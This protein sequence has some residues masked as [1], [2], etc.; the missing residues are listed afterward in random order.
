[1][2]SEDIITAYKNIAVPSKQEQNLPGLDKDIEP[3]IE[4]TKQ[5]IWDD[6]GRPSLREY[7][8]SGK[9][10]GKTAIVTGADSGIGR[11]AVILFARE[12]ARGITIAH[13]PEEKEDAESAKIDL[14]KE[15]A[16]CLLVPCN[17]MEEADCKAVV[18]AHVRVFGTLNILVNN[19]SKQILTKNFEEIDLEKVK[20]TFNSN[21]LQMFAVTK[22]ALPH[23]KRGSSIINTTS[24]TAYKGSASL[25]DYS[26]T[27]GAI[28]TFT[29]SLAVQLAPKGIRVNAIAPGPVVTALQAASRDAEDMEG[30]GVGL[31]LHNRAA[32]PAELGPAYVFLAS[33]D[34]NAMTGAVLHINS[35][36]HIGGS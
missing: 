23:M 17:L 11:S 31:P 24:V 21:I 15:G 36:Q 26:S 3:G 8:G 9:L 33:S 28:V 10:K 4:Y 30:L 25:V 6:E 12:G 34:S 32:Q 2:S 7:V 22:Y 1:M 13:L 20:S 35:G 29:R 16:K 19:A 18:D 5:E 14:E 27:K